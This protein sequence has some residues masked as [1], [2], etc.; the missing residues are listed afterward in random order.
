MSEHASEGAISFRR[1]F[2]RLL[3]FA[4]PI[5]NVVAAVLWLAAGKDE[6]TKNFGKAALLV[7]LILMAV[8]LGLGVVSYGYLQSA[9]LTM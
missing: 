8:A 2:G 7:V 5:A 1:Y 3:I 6:E 9:L 4:I